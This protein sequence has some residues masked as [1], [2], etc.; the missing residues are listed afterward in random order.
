MKLVLRQTDEFQA[1]LNNQDA[2]TTTRVRAR[3]ERVQNEGHFGDHKFFRGLMELRWK[4]GL[5]VYLVRQQNEVVA[6]L[7]GNKHAQTRDID[8]AEKILKREIQTSQTLQ[9]RKGPRKS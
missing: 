7:G 6:L 2:L 3:L 9:T 8:T 4:V 5:R 1:W